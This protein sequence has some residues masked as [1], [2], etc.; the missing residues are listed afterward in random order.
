MGSRNFIDNL[1]YGEGSARRYMQSSPVLYDVWSA[2]AEKPWSR[3][4]LLLTPYRGNKPGAVCVA[5]GEALEKDSNARRISKEKEE[6]E[7]GQNLL[8][9]NQSDVAASL[10]FPQVVRVVLPLTGWWASEVQSKIKKN[11]NAKGSTTDDV[12]SQVLKNEK[13]RF[14]NALE[15][16]RQGNLQSEA[17]LTPDIVWLVQM[18]GSL[19]ILRRKTKQGSHPRPPAKPYPAVQVVNAVMDIMQQLVI[20]QETS[21]ELKPLI[22][23]VNCNRT[24]ATSIDRSTK[25][26]KSDAALRLFEIKCDRIK[27]AVVDSGIDAKHP[28]FCKASDKNGAG[29][30]L[31]FPPTRV[32]ATYDF[33]FIRE[34]LSP[35][36][37]TDWLENDHEPNKEDSP[38]KKRFLKAV[39]QARELDSKKTDNSSELNDLVIKDWRKFLKDLMELKTA[40]LNGRELNWSFMEPFLKI[41]YDDH[42]I[43]PVNDHGT[44]VAGILAAN[45]AESGRMGVCPDINLY[46]IRVLDQQGKGS[47]FNVIAALQ[48]IR[49][50]NGSEDHMVIHGANLSL[51]IKHDVANYACGR[52]PVC[53][54]T[55]RLVASGVCVVAA[56]GNQGYIKY[57]TADGPLEGYHTISITDPGNSEK[58]ITVGATHRY[59]PHT[60]GVSY[61]SSR[62]PTGDGRLKPDLVA[63]GEKIM[64]PTPNRDWQAKD[65]TSM[66]A[67]HVS[68]AA[69]LLMARHREMV[70]RPE[71]I[72]K[73]LCDTATDLGR[74]RYFQ[75][76][77]MLDIL[78]ALQKV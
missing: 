75:G 23:V 47:E 71:Q 72:K 29:E 78:R 13:S 10:S 9:Y 8:A 28:A 52:T 65:G 66:A 12:F 56:A 48:F 35:S 5:L 20:Y 14:E 69:A 1:I 60:Y 40:L 32:Q 2:Y 46:D 74:E 31:G 19:A 43:T 68:G 41:E 34:L 26:I 49:N 55:D 25:A 58:V 44:H 3:Q 59:R 24:A 63:P 45:D 27:W 50:L 64:G 36:Q 57:H 15:G 77:G 18:I 51:S 54:E 30:E 61:F 62:G 11:P 22:H 17:D 73:I 37:L 7:E 21:S 39:R 67:P 38:G 33:S 76:R 16:F 4:D 70:G 6:G 42:Y 53:D